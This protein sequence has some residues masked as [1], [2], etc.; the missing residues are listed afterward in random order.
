M[1]LL[2]G[3]WPYSGRPVVSASLE[4]AA[5]TILAPVGRQAAVLNLDAPRPQ[6]L[7]SLQPPSYVADLDAATAASG[8]V[9][10][11]VR[12][13][14]GGDI[15]RL[16]LSAGQTVPLVSRSG[17][18]ESLSLPFWQPDGSRLLFQRE[19]IQRPGVAYPGQANVRY[20][21]RVESVAADGSGRAVLVDDAR[22]PAVSADGAELAYVRSSSSGT[23]LR[24]RE[25]ASGDERELVP[26]TRFADVAYPRYAPD[27]SVLAF[28]A[29][30]PFV[31]HADGL[32]LFAPAV[33]YAHGL[34]WDVWLIDPHGGEPRQLAALGADDPSL[35]WSPD[36]QQVFVYSGSGS[37]LIDVASGEVDHLDYLAGYGAIA[38]L[39]RS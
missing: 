7:T 5:G 33:A 39:P 24:V 11:E 18:G 3:L 30:A 21:S 32:P 19:D 22:M 37:V 17:A 36:G 1:L 16:D 4:P 27:G 15:V 31:G 14:S 25:L 29:T 10:I 12:D 38:W 26:A 8:Q 28:A 6:L 35:A 9:A 23:V 2:A 20:P 13:S 34:P